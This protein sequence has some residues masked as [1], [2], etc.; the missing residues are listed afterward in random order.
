MT[1]FL[2]LDVWKIYPLLEDPRFEHRCRTITS[3]RC[4]LSKW[5]SSA[6]ITSGKKQMTARSRYER[7]DRAKALLR[8]RTPCR[9]CMWSVGV[10]ICVQDPRSTYRLKNIEVHLTRVPEFRFYQTDNTTPLLYRH[11]RKKKK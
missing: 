2:F 11:G 10:Y 9:V 6:I 1:F 7:R 8:I 3:C 5:L 4:E